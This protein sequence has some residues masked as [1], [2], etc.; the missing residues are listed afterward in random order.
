[1]RFRDRTDAGSQLAEKLAGFDLT[2]PVVLGIPR[3]GVVIAAVIARVLGAELDVV[4][5]RKLPTPGQPELALGAVSEDGHVVINPEVAR[6]VH[7][8]EDEFDAI[9]LREAAEIARRRQLYRAGAQCVPVEGRT[10]IVTDDGIATGATMIAAL[11]ELRTRQPKELILAVPV[12]ATSRLS[13]VRRWADR[14][15]CL[16]DTDELHAV[17]Q[18]YDDF[19][20]VEDAEVV[21]TLRN[22]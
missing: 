1:M 2:D 6:M 13:E 22:A 14:T 4:L 5:S 19:R 8:A 21:G 18:F 16:F 11:Q 17:G 20:Q 15:V 10:V 3:G 7:F 12:A 9:R